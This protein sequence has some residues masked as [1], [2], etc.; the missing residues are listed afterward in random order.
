MKRG[1]VVLLLLLSMLLPAVGASAHD[2]SWFRTWPTS[3]RGDINVIWA[4]H[5]WET[6]NLPGGPGRERMKDGAA[7]WNALTSSDLAFKFGTYDFDP[8]SRSINCQDNAQ[9]YNA[10]FYRYYDDRDSPNDLPSSGTVS[11]CLLDEEVFNFVMQIN[12]YYDSQWYTGTSEVPTGKYSLQGTATHEFGHAAGFQG[13]WDT[14]PQGTLASPGSNADPSL[15]PTDYTVRHTMCAN[16]V[17]KG[18][19]Q[20]SLEQHDSHT[21]T[22]RYG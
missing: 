8:D 4:S 21:F 6:G 1:P 5:A 20:N 12:S 16:F 2:A 14:G 22:N 3:V 18:A 11:R 13:H 10:T 9:N 19:Y 17:G 15:C 7:T